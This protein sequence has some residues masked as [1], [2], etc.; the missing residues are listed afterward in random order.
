MWKILLMHE[1]ITL[2]E[3]LPQGYEHGLI[4]IATLRDKK[5]L[6]RQLELLVF[7]KFCHLTP[8]DG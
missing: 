4:N 2:F 1:H 8:H 3:Y 6:N 7:R 5:S